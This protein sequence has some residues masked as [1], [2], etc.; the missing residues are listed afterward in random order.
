MSGTVAAED[1]SE[2][3][4]AARAFNQRLLTHPE[5]IGTLTPVGDGVLIAVKK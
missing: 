2:R 4:A 1:G 3:T 5:L